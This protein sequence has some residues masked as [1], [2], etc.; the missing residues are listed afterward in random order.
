MQSGTKVGY[1]RMP[2]QILP[3]LEADACREAGHGD[4]AYAEE[5]IYE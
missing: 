5:D 1:L 2:I 4:G 3:V